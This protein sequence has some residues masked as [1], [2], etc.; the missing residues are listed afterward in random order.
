MAR[1]DPDGVLSIFH[2]MSSLGYVVTAMTG[3]WIDMGEIPFV[4]EH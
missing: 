1:N 2:C 3:A 4:C